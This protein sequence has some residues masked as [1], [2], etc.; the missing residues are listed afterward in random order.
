[1]SKRVELKIKG[2]A[3]DGYKYDEIFTD[4]DFIG[5]AD[6]EMVQ[7]VKDTYQ[8]F[9]NSEDDEECHRT[10]ISITKVEIIEIETELF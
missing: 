3:S 6:D 9:N 10:L 7:H 2:M 1:M 4:D 8:N 5:M